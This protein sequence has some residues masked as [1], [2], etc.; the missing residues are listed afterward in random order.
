[1]YKINRI[2]KCILIVFLAVYFLAACKKEKKTYTPVPFLTGRAWIADTITI[3]P[4]ATYGQLS[5]SDQ[6]S[7][8]N[9]LSWFKAH[10]TFNEDNTVTC[11]GDYD[12]G[13]KTWRL[14]N[15]NADIEVFNTNGIKHILRNWVADAVHLSYTEQLNN[16]F[17][18]SLIYK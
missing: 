9:A 14:V 4:P 7:Y 3:N 17:D 11:G 5:N 8:R 2:S 6:T 12:L 16:S 1:M 13:Y 10:L 18:C 15:N